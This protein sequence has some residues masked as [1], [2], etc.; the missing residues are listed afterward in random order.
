MKSKT[1][2]SLKS[3]IGMQIGFL[4]HSDKPIDDVINHLHELALDY[5]SQFQQP[6][7]KDNEGDYFKLYVRHSGN[8]KDITIDYIRGQT[9][10]T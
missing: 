5:A 10:K 3:N 7:V 4:L 6:E 9:K 8:D 1:A 2:E